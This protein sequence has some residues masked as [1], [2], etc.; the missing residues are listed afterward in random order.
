[1]RLEEVEKIN[2]CEGDERFMRKN[3]VGDVMTRNRCVR[4]WK[5]TR[6]GTVVNGKKICHKKEEVCT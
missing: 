4:D 5:K 3:C 2:R 1:M 6:K